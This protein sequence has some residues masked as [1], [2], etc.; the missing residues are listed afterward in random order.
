MTI[1]CGSSVTTE[2]NRNTRR[3]PAM[4]G[5]VKLDNTVLSCDQGNFS[6][7]TARR[8]NRTVASGERH[9]HYHCPTSTPS[10]STF[11][12]RNIKTCRVL[13]QFIVDFLVTVQLEVINCRSHSLG[14][15]LPFSEVGRAHFHHCASQRRTA[16]SKRCIYTVEFLLTIGVSVYA[17]YLNSLKTTQEVFPKQI[18]YPVLVLYLRVYS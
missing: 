10:E 3:K 1:P 12:R 6:L 7:T 17:V 11:S 13:L 18:Y 14:F 16:I 2:G 5:R 8:R 9:M 4:L 15:H